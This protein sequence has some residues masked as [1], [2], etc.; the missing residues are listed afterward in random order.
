VLRLPARLHWW[1]N[2][3]TSIAGGSAQFSDVAT[4]E[5]AGAALVQGMDDNSWNKAHYVCVPQPKNT[6]MT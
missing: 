3:A 5:A 2:F 4:C 1:I 6:V